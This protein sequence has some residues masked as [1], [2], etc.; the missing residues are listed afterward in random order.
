MEQI[1]FAIKSVRETEYYVNESL[2]LDDQIDYTL[3]AGLDIRT[4]VNEIHFIVFASF[5]RKG[6]TEDYLRGK[7]ISTFLFENLKSRAA[8]KDGKEVVDL[9]DSLWVTLFSIS[10]T[11]ARAMLAK[12]SAGTKFTHLI[13]PIVNPDAQFK[14]IFRNEL[15]PETTHPSSN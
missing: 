5:R 2:E 3:N 9:P 1:G 12:S 7:T 14:K 15:P 13:L 8:I 10:Y 4:N 6:T 11:H